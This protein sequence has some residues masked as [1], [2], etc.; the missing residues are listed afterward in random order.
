VIGEIIAS[1]YRTIRAS[2]LPIASQHSLVVP[3]TVP[4]N[5]DKEVEECVVFLTTDNLERAELDLED[6]R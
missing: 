3:I 2:T 6:P 5:V 1:E 4:I